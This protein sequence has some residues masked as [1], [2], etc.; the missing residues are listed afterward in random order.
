MR[1]IKS[2]DA[3][4]VEHPVFCLYGQPGIGKSSIGYSAKD[5]LLL[6]FDQGAHRAANRRDTMV[7]NAWADVKELMDAPDTLAPYATVIVDTVGR[8]LD[9]ITADIIQTTPK[10]GRDGS[11]TLQGY[12]ALK[13]RFRT[14]MTQLRT[15][16]K[17]VVLL[18]H[19]KEDGDADNRIVRPDI[20]GGSYAE[21]MKISDF[22]G[23]VCMSGKNRV[24]DFS[25]TDRW[26]GKNPG[27][28]NP[29][30]LPPV[31]KAQ[32]FLGG[33]IDQ[34]RTVLG[35]ISEAS[36]SVASVVDDWRAQIETFTE[37]DELTKAIPEINKLSAVAAPQVKKL[38]M[39]RAKA[40]G[41]PFDTKSH[42]FT[43]PA[44]EP[45]PA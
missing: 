11:L 12:G 25:P 14:W 6:D 40:L 9:L 30:V 33:L 27:N 16:G 19:D 39:A 7:I 5:P 22:V 43:A 24:L 31:A 3:I 10:H 8:C 45:V 42:A 13:T 38:L 44:K 23:Y 18:A 28:W 1:I 17:E 4:P 36:A 26:V 29:L 35:A 15:L 21:V 37:P 32:D 2:T 20:T 41:Y 34:G